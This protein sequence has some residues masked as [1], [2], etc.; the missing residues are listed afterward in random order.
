MLIGQKMFFI[1]LW[2]FC[3]KDVFCCDTYLISYTQDACRNACKSAS[4][5]PII[6]ASLTKID[7]CLEILTY[8]GNVKFYANNQNLFSYRQADTEILI[9]VFL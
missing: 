5:V 9:G 7:I 2:D 4:K 8:L 3:A 1:S 6:Y